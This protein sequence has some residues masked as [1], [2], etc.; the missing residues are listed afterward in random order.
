MM[1]RAAI[2]IAAITSSF[3]ALALAPGA[4]K[5]GTPRALIPVTGMLFTPAP[6]RPIAFTLRGISIVRMSWERTMT[7]S[8]SALSAPTSYRSDGKR[9]SPRGE[10]ELSVW[11]RKR[12]AMRALELPHVIDQRL[13]AF[14]RHRVVDR[15][16]H[17]ADR[18]VPLQ[19]REARGFRALQE[20][21]VQRVAL[22]R[23]RNVHARTVVLRDGRMVELGLVEIVVD[24]ARLA[25]VDFLHRLEPAEPFQ[26]LEDESRYVDRVRRRR[27]VHRI[28]VGLHLVVEDRGRDR[29]GVADQVVAHDED[30]KSRGPYVFLRP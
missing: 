26:P 2:S 12:S 22:Q 20:R 30:R 25:N 19:L 17:A 7:A 24:E 5:T 23:E 1:L 16:P 8:G 15:R 13:H 10:I 18:A 9:F 11:M 21:A 14:D 28:V 3:T 4:L 29:Q 6:A 27:V